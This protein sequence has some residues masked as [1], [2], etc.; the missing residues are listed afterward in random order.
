MFEILNNVVSV[1]T[2]LDIRGIVVRL[3]IRARDIFSPQGPDLPRVHPA[4]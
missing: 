3:S 2:R 4:S 1:Q